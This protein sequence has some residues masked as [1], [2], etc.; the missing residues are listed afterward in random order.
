MTAAI[1]IQGFRGIRK[2]WHY[3]KGV[4]FTPETIETA[5]KL[6]DFAIQLGIKTDAFPET[7]GAIMLVAYLKKQFEFVVSGR[8]IAYR[9][10][11]SDEEPEVDAIENTR[12]QMLLWSLAYA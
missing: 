2:G 11:E 8:S 7:N 10:F 3:G 1:K 4:E 9:E 6:N 12:A 5:G